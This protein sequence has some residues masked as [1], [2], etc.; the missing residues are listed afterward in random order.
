MNAARML[1]L[2]ASVFGGLAVT[3]SIALFAIRS[4]N[5]DLDSIHLAISGIV[6]DV[7]VIP[8]IIFLNVFEWNEVIFPFSLNDRS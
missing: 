1:P 5:Y 8:M 3:H 6:M 7:M 4:I 2:A